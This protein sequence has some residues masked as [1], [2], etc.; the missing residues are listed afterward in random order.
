M[1]LIWIVS[2][3]GNEWKMVKDLW[4]IFAFPDDYPFLFK[5]YIL[6]LYKCFDHINVVFCGIFSM[7]PTQPSCYLEQEWA[8]LERGWDLN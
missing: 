5:C 2:R 1:N 3:Y 8:S 6:N 7:Q 4:K